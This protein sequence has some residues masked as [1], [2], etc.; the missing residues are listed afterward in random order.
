AGCRETSPA[1]EDQE[2][3]RLAF[4]AHAFPEGDAIFDLRSRG[5]RIGVIP[6]GVFAAHPVDVDVVIVRGALPRAN[7]GVLAGLEEFLPH[8]CQ[9]KVLIPFHHHC[10][11][12]LRD[13]LSTPQCLSHGVLSRVSGPS[14]CTRS[15]PYRAVATAAA[16]SISL[17]SSAESL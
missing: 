4:D 11:I 15:L 8:R 14:H 10:R 12:A 16:D 17:T 5:L 1:R 9:G 7:A 3:P 2:L 13:D 6:R